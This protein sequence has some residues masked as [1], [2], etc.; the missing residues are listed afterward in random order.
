MAN[1]MPCPKGT[2]PPRISTTMPSETKPLAAAM[3]IKKV[4]H[5]GMTHPAATKARQQAAASHTVWRKGFSTTM[6]QIFRA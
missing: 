3:V 1:T 2:T 4:N 5:L 6:A